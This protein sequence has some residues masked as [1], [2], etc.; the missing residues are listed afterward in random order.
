MGRHRGIANHQQ[1]FIVGLVRGPTPI[2]G[3]HHHGFTVDH[4]KFMVQLVGGGQG[5]DSY[6]G[7]GLGPGLVVG[8]HAAIG[9]WQ[10]QTQHIQDFAVATVGKAGVNQGFDRDPPLAHRLDLIAQALVR[11]DKEG[12]VEAV[13]GPTQGP[14]N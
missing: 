4:R 14:T 10:G 12:Q 7:Q 2:V 11:E 9:I 5:R 1:V 13:A 3:A 8:L 6:G